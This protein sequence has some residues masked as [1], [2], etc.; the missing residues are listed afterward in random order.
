MLYIYIYIYIEVRSGGPTAVADPVES[1]R[2]HQRLAPRATDEVGAP[3][4]N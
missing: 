4:P 2:S 3:E 1:A